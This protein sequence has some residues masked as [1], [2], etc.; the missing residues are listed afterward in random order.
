MRERGLKPRMPGVDTPAAT[1]L[2]MRERGLKL[3]VEFAP[4]LRVGVAPHA[5]A[6]IETPLIRAALLRA[7]S[8]PMRERGLKH[9]DNHRRFTPIMSLPMRERGLKRSITSA[10][11]D[12]RRSLP[13]RE[14]GLKHGN[15]ERG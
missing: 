5:G 10:A 14:R 9:Q 4:R 8:L 11:S 13:M 2:P 12:E 15:S 6:W 1:S 7:S 3:A